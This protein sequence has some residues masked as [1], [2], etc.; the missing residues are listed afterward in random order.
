MKAKSFLRRNILWIAGI[1]FLGFHFG[2]YVLQKVA[3]SSAR[4]TVA[5]KDSKDSS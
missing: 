4:E 3:K 1:S 2:T 5:V